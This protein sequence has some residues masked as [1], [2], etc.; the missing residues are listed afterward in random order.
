MGSIRVVLA[1][2]HRVVRECIRQYLEKAGDIEVVG[3]ARD[4]I[5]A[6]DQVA[7]KHPDILVLDMEMPKLNGREILKQLAEND[8][9][10]R[11]LILSA[12][13]DR[14]Y[15]EE[16]IKMGVA[17]YLTKDEIPE[18]IVKA[19]RGIAQGQEGWISKG[20]S[21]WLGS[22]RQHEGTEPNPV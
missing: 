7:D 8:T 15:V 20:A 6:L 1:D 14:Y 13:N 10:T 5:E 9:G 12:Y 17:G 22:S 3:E 18:Q 21:I 16:T 4:G 2:D 11:V 19:V